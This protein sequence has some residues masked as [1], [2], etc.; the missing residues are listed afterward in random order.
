MRR[1]IPWW[2]ILAIVLL[3][4]AGTKIY[5]DGVNAGKQETELRE[6]K[7]SIKARD[8]QLLAVMHQRDAAARAAVA[9]GARSD[10]TRR[11]YT[12]SRIKVELRGDTATI[13]G[14]S[15][16]HI[17]PGAVGDLIR[18]SDIHI[19]ALETENRLLRAQVA[20]DDDLIQGQRI[21][22][23]AKDKE[24]SLLEK[25]KAPRCGAKCGAVLGALAVLGAAIAF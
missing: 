5:F 16:E 25:Q 24:I 17:L 20:I 15:V 23:E 10:S 2:P 12:R 13:A 6:V 22:L 21:Q 14:D 4:G 11:A 3:A 9:A 7:A 8:A 18:A 19:E 1:L